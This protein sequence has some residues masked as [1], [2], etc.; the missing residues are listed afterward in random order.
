MDAKKKPVDTHSLSTFEV[1][2]SVG[3]AVTSITDAPE[4]SAGRKVE[5]DGEAYKEIIGLLVER[6]VI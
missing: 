4:R 6:K 1:D 3:Q 2:V 5:D